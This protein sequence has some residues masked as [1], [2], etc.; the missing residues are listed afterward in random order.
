MV[1]S[2]LHL[3]WRAHV[4]WADT[5]DPPRIRQSDARRSNRRPTATRLAH[6]ISTP[7]F[8]SRRA[9]RAT[10]A[11]RRCRIWGSGFPRSTRRWRKSSCSRTCPWRERPRGSGTFSANSRSQRRPDRNARRCIPPCGWRLSESKESSRSH[12]ASRHSPTMPTYRTV[13]SPDSFKRNS[14]RASS[15]ISRIDEWK[16]PGSCSESR[17]FL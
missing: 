13:T 11:F 1:P 16:K 12:S 9:H 4:A 6:C 17:R 10:S 8:A 15:D 14:A 2:P 5:A 7:T 3:S